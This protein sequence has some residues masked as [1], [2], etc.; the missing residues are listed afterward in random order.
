MTTAGA[1]L[2]LV[3]GKIASGKSTLATKLAEDKQA[4]LV[5]EDKWLA[6][7]FP[8]EIAKIPDYVKYSGRLRNVIGA[9]VPELLKQRQSVV[10]DFPA[11]TV[12]IRQ[13]MVAM[14]RDGR[15][16]SEFHFLDVPDDVC[17]ERLRFRNEA[18]EHEFSASEEDFEQI[19]SFFQTPDAKKVCIL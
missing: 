9:H 17:K 11:N 18:G 14:A 7:L 1:K 16:D 6:A 4:V 12:K 5:R 10:L 13:W 3:V 15:A 19:S 2:Y 8:E